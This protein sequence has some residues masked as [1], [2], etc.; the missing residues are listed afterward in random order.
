MKNLFPFIK[1][2]LRAYFYSPI[3][4]IVAGVFLGLI[5]YFFFSSMQGF[6]MQAV[7]LSGS[8]KELSGFNPTNVIMKGLFRSMG[9]I[10][11][12]LTPLITMRL[13]AEE[14]RTRTMELLMTSP[15]SITTII[16]GKYVA[17]LIIYVL[18]IL[19]TLYIPLT[20]EYF[21]TVSWWHVLSAYA[22]VV[23]LG[24]AMISVGVFCSSV[25][26]KQVVA[27]V[28]TIGILVLFWFVGGVI[29]SYSEDI[30][31]VM[32]EISLFGHFENL[33]NGLFDTRDVVY[34]VSFSLVALFLSHRA[35]ESGRWK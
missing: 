23:L 2:E 11:I 25:T 18:I 22:G 7:Q 29:G 4:Y 27:A 33:Y 3:A 6:S 30:S 17:A 5:G 19:S 10:F 9:T 16:M 34:L 1:K 8:G 28:L 26:D 20:I 32:K 35:L 31:K 12:L 24:M 21:S 15:L 13:I 14:K